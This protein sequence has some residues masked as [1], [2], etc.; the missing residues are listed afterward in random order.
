[1]F[2]LDLSIACDIL[3]GVVAGRILSGS[4]KRVYIT[5]LKTGNVKDRLHKFKEE[6][7]S[8]CEDLQDL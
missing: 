8:I 3:K 6:I 7:Y 5:C 2:F 4:E 1:M